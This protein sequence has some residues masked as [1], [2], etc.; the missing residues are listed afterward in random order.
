MKPKIYKEKLIQLKEE[1]MAAF[2]RVVDQATEL[3]ILNSPRTFELL[4]TAF[5][6]YEKLENIE[7]LFVK[8]HS[9]KDYTLLYQLFIIKTIADVWWRLP[10]P[11]RGL[12]NSVPELKAWKARYR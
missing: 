7:R 3:L 11:I 9:R 1:K 5:K 2:Q 10:V 4:Y 12:W 6:E 8:K